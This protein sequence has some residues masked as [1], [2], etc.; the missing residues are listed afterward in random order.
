MIEDCAKILYM[1][2]K[3][4]FIV[5]TKMEEGYYIH[6]QMDCVCILGHVGIK[7]NLYGETYMGIHDGG[8]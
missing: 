8:S 3:T 5:F 7:A 4:F 2:K 6:I 1:K